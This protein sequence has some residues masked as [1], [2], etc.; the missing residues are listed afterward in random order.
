MIIGTRTNKLPKYFELSHVLNL[1]VIL[2]GR[3]HT[4]LAHAFDALQSD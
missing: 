2:D 1:A 3:H 4:W